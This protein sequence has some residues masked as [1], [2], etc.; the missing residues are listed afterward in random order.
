MSSTLD[1]TI[2]DE[3]AVAN[4]SAKAGIWGLAAVLWLAVVLA[5]A[6]HQWR[7]WQ[8]ARLNTDV[9]ALLPVNEQNPEVLA[10]TRTL[11][12][13][14]SRQVV[15]TVGAPDW[16]A[17]QAAA[18]AWR[19]A[20][21][22][23]HAPLRPSQAASPDG[24]GAALEFYRPWRDRLL[25]HAQ[26]EQ[27]AR[28]APPALVQESL[29][30]LYQPGAAP[31][32][33]QWASDPLGLW[34]QWWAERAA[35]S[36]ARPR[37]GALWLAG[38]GLEWEVMSYETTGPAF[39]LDGDAVYGDALWAARDAALKAQPNA[40]ILEAGLPLHAEAAAVQASHEVNTIGWGSLAAVLLLIWTAFRSVRPMLLVALSLAIGTATALSVTAWIFGEVHLLTLVF[41]ATLVGVAEDYGIH[42]FASRQG[43]PQ[44]APRN[45]MRGLLPGL[46]LALVT[47]VVGY[48][49]LGL[50]PFP[51]L[52]QMA[53]FS[54]IGLI[55]AFLTAICWFPL[56]DRGV[57]PRSRFAHWVGTSLRRMP[58]LQLSPRTGAAALTAGVLCVA[59]ALQLHAGDD[60]R[61]LQNS[62][63]A[64]VKNQLELGRLIGVP[65]VAQ[66]YLIQG[67]EPQEVLEREESLKQ[68]LDVLIAEGRLGG[69]SA[70]SDW[71]PSLARQKADA[72]I[73]ARAESAV[74]AGVGAALGEKLVRPAFSETPLTVQA[75]LAHP[76]SAPMRGQWLPHADGSSASVVLLRGVQDVSQLP[77]LAAAPEGLEGV[78][79]AD[80]AGEVSSLLGRYRVSMTWLLVAG[81]LA[82]LGAL[83]WRYGAAGWRALA[84]TAIASLA[85]VAVLGWTGQ[86]FQLFHV[87]ALVLLLGIG[88]D[89]GIFLMEHPQDGSAWLAVVLGAGSTW[90]A[91]G[92]LGLSGT[93][94][95]RAF[96]LTLMLGIALVWILSP[97]LC[98]GAGRAIAKAQQW[99]A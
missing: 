60:I 74:L 33:S 19:Q 51:G 24:L 79:W 66:F 59:G 65:S 23:T 56:L 72:Q 49:V 71:V 43:H 46:A 91:F 82:V 5:V 90:L 11:A 77:A 64:L 20:M 84:P 92:L 83:L 30:A 88:V 97:W 95:L 16:P 96:G 27:L 22:A 73:T 35:Q 87:L 28:S 25:T 55:A 98:A 17:A 45:L 58:V 7:F 61:Q 69:Y 53:V 9:L 81:Y 86:P 18:A 52:R 63:A 99:P 93:P 62:P 70:V 67:G 34:R 54:A 21:E 4:G 94:A 6:T 68:R 40:R 80:I 36:H 47:S 38:E 48:L 12:E 85:T 14:A 32:L 2:P 31:R 29:A 89:Y 37:D 41:G 15:V 42:Y 1:Q 26:R 13:R 78:R 75:W 39:A 44:A 57:V 3:S 10:A 76:V 50:A 8:E